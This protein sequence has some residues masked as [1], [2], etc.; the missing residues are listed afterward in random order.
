VHLV[1]PLL[2]ESAPSVLSHMMSL[3]YLYTARRSKFEKTLV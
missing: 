2:L 1:A 3:L